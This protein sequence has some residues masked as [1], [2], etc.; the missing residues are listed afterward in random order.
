LAA[1]PNGDARDLL[2]EAGTGLLCRPADVDC[3]A[4]TLREQLDRFQL[5]L[6]AP[7]PKPDV[8]ARYDYRSLTRALANVFDT[9]DGPTAQTTSGARLPLAQAGR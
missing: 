3:L 9:A 8:V 1:V 7:E 2:A 6:A 4:R 5:G